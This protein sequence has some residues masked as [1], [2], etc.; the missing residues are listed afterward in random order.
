MLGLYLSRFGI[1]QQLSGLDKPRDINHEYGTR[2][3]NSFRL[4]NRLVVPASGVHPRGLVSSE[5]PSAAPL[6]IGAFPLHG[7][8]DRCIASI[9]CPISDFQLC[10]PWRRRIP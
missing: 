6:K 8:P 4:G 3:T 7:T 10:A 2:I 9:S 1:T 5:G